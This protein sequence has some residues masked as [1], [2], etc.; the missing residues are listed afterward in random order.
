MFCLFL[1]GHFTQ[2]LLY[3]CCF[4]HRDL[5]EWDTA[6]KAAIENFKKEREYMHTTTVNLVAKTL[7]L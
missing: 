7:Q 3:L 4:F 1:S 2:V 5:F 6:K